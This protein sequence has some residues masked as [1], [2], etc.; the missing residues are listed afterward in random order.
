MDLSQHLDNNRQWTPMTQTLIILSMKKQLTRPGKVASWTSSSHSRTHAKILLPVL[1]VL[2]MLPVLY[3]GLPP[4]DDWLAFFRRWL[5][6]DPDMSSFVFFHVYL[7]MG[8][9][10]VF[11]SVRALIS[12]DYETPGVMLVL[13]LCS[14][15]G[16]SSNLPGWLRTFCGLYG[17]VLSG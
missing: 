12:R 7:I 8:I 4:S 5:Q 14:L 16:L 1:L 10:S 17:I 13:F 6:V 2:A 3:A 9:Y 11:I 15:I